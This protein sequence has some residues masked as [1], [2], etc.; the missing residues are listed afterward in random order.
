M[1]MN[2]P[3]L[4]PPVPDLADRNAAACALACVKVQ[5]QTQPLPV[6]PHE[7]YALILER[8]DDLKA[9]VF[10]GSRARAREDALRVGGAAMALL[11]TLAEHVDLDDVTD[12]VIAELERAQRRFGPYVSPHEAY[13]V[14]LE[15]ADELWD[16][17]KRRDRVAMWG[18]GV[19]VAAVALR[20]HIDIRE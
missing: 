18:E 13:A 10:H 17:V 1:T 20:F 2:H 11:L 15:E 12:A 9:E 7:G 3:V 6:G 14:I 8:L 5:R 16:E 4:D 19:Q